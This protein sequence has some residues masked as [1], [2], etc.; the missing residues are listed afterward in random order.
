MSVTPEIALDVAAAFLKFFLDPATRSSGDA[1]AVY[2]A[3]SIVH[4]TKEQENDNVQKS[5][6]QGKT[7]IG[8]YMMALPP[9]ALTLAHFDAVGTNHGV[10]V[11]AT[12]NEIIDIVDFPWHRSLYLIPTPQG[13]YYLKS[14]LL[15]Y[16]VGK[17]LQPEVIQIE[18]EQVIA[19]AVAPV[20]V[21]VPVPVPAPVET[22]AAAPV[23]VDE[24]AAA[25]VVVPA[26]KNN[27]KKPANRPNAKK[28]A[29]AVAVTPAASDDAAVAAPVDV[30][31]QE[32][33]V[34][35]VVPVVAD[36]PVV[37]D[38]VV[39]VAEVAE[40]VKQ[41]KPAKK[42]KPMSWAHAVD[43]EAAVPVAVAP[44]KSTPVNKKQDR[45]PIDPANAAAQVFVKYIPAE[46]TRDQL[47]KESAAAFGPVAKVI[48]N[49]QKRI[50]TVIFKEASAAAQ[51][52]Q[53]GSL[54][55]ADGKCTIVPLLKPGNKFPR[56][57]APK[58]T[59][60]NQQPEAAKN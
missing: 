15:H 6:F 47:F 50:A 7:S 59:N 54:A 19:P 51:A 57:N 36:E 3:D 24:A 11:S 32:A 31:P 26:K 37:A 48:F 21:P 49:D 23:V 18:D 10:L 14:D 5:T 17:P 44:E 55:I 13:G 52:L 46:V 45:K 43:P 28:A 30:A 39:E 16:Q 1:F 38:V 53:T 27:K 34:V 20:A 33:E 9:S 42:A 8:D 22:E 56:Q 29:D 35:E 25:A 41:E 2:A 60:T 58:A 12:G 40:P 4:V